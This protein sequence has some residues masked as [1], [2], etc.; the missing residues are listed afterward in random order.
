MLNLLLLASDR[1]PAVYKHL[2]TCS[3]IAGCLLVDMI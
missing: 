2:Q 1:L 3:G